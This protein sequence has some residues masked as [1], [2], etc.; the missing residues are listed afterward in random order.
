M[1]DEFPKFVIRYELNLLLAQIRIKEKRQVF[2]GA[3]EKDDT[4]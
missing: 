4:Q 3:G 2:M 1:S